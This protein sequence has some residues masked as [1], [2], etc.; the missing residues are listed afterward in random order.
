MTKDQNSFALYNNVRNMGNARTCFRNLSLPVLLLAP[1]ST[2]E[3]PAVIPTYLYHHRY[4]LTSK[5][6]RFTARDFPPACCAWQHVRR[7]AV[8]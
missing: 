4:E 6:A 1:C 5:P 2:P 7:S 3:R 8:S